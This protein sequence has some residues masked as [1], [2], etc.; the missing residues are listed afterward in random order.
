LVAK[1]GLA[2]VPPHGKMGVVTAQA[3][4]PLQGLA[5]LLPGTRA[6]PAGDGV[7]FVPVERPPY[8]W[9]DL[10]QVPDDGNRYE[11]I[12]G[13]LLVTP[14]PDTE[15]ADI[16]EA[17]RDVLRTGAPGGVAVYTSA[18][19]VDLGSSVP[20]PDLVAFRRRPGRRPAVDPADIL[21]VAEVVSAGR[22]RVDHER[23]RRTYAAA[24]IAHYWIV[25][26]D[27]IRLTVLC[28]RGMDYTEAGRASGE[29]LL[30]VTEPFPLAFRPADLLR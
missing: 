23:K 24:G 19:G 2:R 15:H 10:Q 30:A 11:I 13:G 18:L 25:D 7:L 6:E 9:A 14:P 5:G 22:E 3:L 16:A 8:Q 12:D 29:E 26:R 27:P 21:L 1:L 4:L 20:I 28:L 17:L